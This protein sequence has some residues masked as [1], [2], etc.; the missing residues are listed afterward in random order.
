MFEELFTASPQ[1]LQAWKQELPALLLVTASILMSWVFW[2]RPYGN[3]KANRMLSLLLWFFSLSLFRDTL[4]MLNV[5]VQEPQWFFFPIWFTWALGPLYFFFVKFTLY[6]AYSWHKSD[7]KHAFFPLLQIAL[8]TTLFFIQYQPE[9]WFYTRF[10]KTLEGGFFV[11]SFFTYLAMSWRYAKFREAVLRHRSHYPWEMAKI[12]WL[13]RNTLIFF[14]LATCNSF[15]LILDFTMFKLFGR[16]LRVWNV[17]PY[18]THYSFALLTLWVFFIAWQLLRRSYM[19]RLLQKLSP[20]QLQEQ[21]FK[22]GCLYDPDFRLKLLPSAARNQLLQA[23]GR[24]AEKQWLNEQR[25]QLLQSEIER[26]RST[27]SIPMR[28]LLQR[29]VFEVGFHSF[30]QYQKLKKHLQNS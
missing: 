28:Y 2:W 23:F 12:S 3:V 26:K 4:M 16:S 9:S 18:L 27:S 11:L 7:V 8:Y 30:R 29:L 6:P 13:K 19:R 20:T 25:L 5:F 22:Q 10:Y 24:K 17:Y 21:L 14:F 15:F 1:L